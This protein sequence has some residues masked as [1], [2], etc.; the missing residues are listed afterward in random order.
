MKSL[1]TLMTALLLSASVAMP[2]M[3]AAD[4]DNAKGMHFKDSLSVQYFLEVARDRKASRVNNKFAFKSG[5][6]IRFHLKSNIDG[7][8]YIVL[9]SKNDP[10]QILFPTA[11]MSQDTESG[12]K[13]RLPRQVDHAT[14]LGFA[15][16]R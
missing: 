6:E 11:R 12:R 14:W 8:A 1:R 2:A 3:M 5:D 7:Y 16:V 15:S 9:R 10:P 4:E 13:P